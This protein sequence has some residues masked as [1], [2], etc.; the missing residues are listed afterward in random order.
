MITFLGGPLDGR[1]QRHWENMQQV[2]LK[3][4]SRFYLY[5][6]QDLTTQ[7]VFLKVLTEK[8]LRQYNL[9]KAPSKIVKASL[10]D[11]VFPQG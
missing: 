2:L 11:R 5:Q 1:R 10:F 8:E 4:N 9:K 3:V 7:F 6:K